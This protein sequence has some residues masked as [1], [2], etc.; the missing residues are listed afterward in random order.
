MVV[1]RSTKSFTRSPRTRKMVCARN[2][3]ISLSFE[4]TA[5]SPEKSS[6]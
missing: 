4:S 3:T 6:S 2:E 5:F 1:Y